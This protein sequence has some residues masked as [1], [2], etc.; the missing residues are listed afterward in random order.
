MTFVMKSKEENDNE[1][2]LSNN[3]SVSKLE[4]KDTISRTKELRKALRFTYMRR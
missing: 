3:K 2:K 1:V 4:Q